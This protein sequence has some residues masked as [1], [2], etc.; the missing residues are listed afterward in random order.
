VPDEC[1]DDALANGVRDVVDIMV[2][3]SLEGLSRRS[4]V[5]WF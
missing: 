5:V 1:V 4:T 3:A 2:T